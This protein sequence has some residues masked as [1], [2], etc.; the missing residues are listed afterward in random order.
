MISRTTP[1]HRLQRPRRRRKRPRPRG[2]SRPRTQRRRG[3]LGVGRRHTARFDGTASGRP[4][5]KAMCRKGAGQVINLLHKLLWY[6][7]ASQLLSGLLAPC[8]WPAEP[9]APF[10]P[11]LLSK[12]MLHFTILTGKKQVLQSS[13]DFSLS[14]AWVAIPKRSSWQEYHMSQSL[15]VG[16]SCLSWVVE[17]NTKYCICCIS[18]TRLQW[19]LK[20]VGFASGGQCPVLSGKS[21]LPQSSTCWCMRMKNHHS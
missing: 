15:V 16:S 17:W 11:E 12:W 8:C 18:K 6:F 21:N 9:C 3:R 4:G 13:W 7:R 10:F 19:C 14:A 5:T 1:L 2:R 20:T